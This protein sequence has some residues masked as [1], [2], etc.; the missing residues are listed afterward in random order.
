MAF[1]SFDR[2]LYEEGKRRGYNDIQL[3]AA[4]GNRRAESG[5]NPLSAIGDR[6]LGPGQEAFG[7]FQWRLDRQ[8]A[9]RQSGDVNDPMTQVKFFFNELEGPE[10]KAGG[11]LK[12]A[13]DINSAQG[14]MQ[15]YLRYRDD[16]G[17]TDKRKQFAQEAYQM[18]TGGQLPAMSPQAMAGQGIMNQQAQP[19]DP[20][21]KDS[22]VQGGPL[23]LFGQGQKD[24]SWGDALLGVAAS[25]AAPYSPQQASVYAQMM[26]KPNRNN[27]RYT[28][29]LD[30][31]SGNLIKLDR[32]TGQ[33]SQQQYTTPEGKPL[34]GSAQK[35]FESND[36]IILERMQQIQEGND[37]RDLIRQG[38]LDPSVIAR[39]ESAINDLMNKGTP[40]ALAQARLS[41][42]LMKNQNAVLMD[43]NGV[44]TEGDAQR[45]LRQILGGT[46]QFSKDQVYA[47]LGDTL[48]S[49]GPD[50]QNRTRNTLSIVDQYKGFDP[51]GEIRKEW[52]TRLRSVN[53]MLAK[54]E[55]RNRGFLTNRP[56]TGGAPTGG[57]QTRDIRKYDR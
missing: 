47:A 5:G 23:A 18:I 14:A 3:A 35:S 57:G 21:Y 50:I 25:L 45:A 27:D 28:V 53:E 33:V 20:A 26:S 39:S 13:Q 51:R 37:L 22:F 56:S 43:A 32:Q 52:D 55:E 8:N 24:Y 38:V 36:K 40:E 46:A 17:V 7:G 9:L 41:R 49:F 4:I 15:Q 1:T 42:F 31:K 29:T 6:N 48:K 34:S 10:N 11:M 12:G 44:Q 16:P 54:E 30:E 2:M 19:Q